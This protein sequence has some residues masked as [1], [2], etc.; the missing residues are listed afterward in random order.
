[1]YTYQG[2]EMLENSPAE[3]DLGVLTDSKL[4]MSLGGLEGQSYPGVHQVQHC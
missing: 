3:R 2:D 4:H 1:M